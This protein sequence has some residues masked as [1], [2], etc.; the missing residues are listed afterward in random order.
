MAF[1]QSS[2]YSFPK[3]NAISYEMAIGIAYLQY[4]F[5]LNSSRGGILCSPL[6]KSADLLSNDQ[7]FDML[8]ICQNHIQ[9]FISNNVT[10]STLTYI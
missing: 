3:Y 8:L 6:T 2:L 1:F 5:P 7:K 9:I 4:F 10:T